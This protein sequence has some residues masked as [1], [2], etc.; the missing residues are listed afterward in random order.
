ML[1]WEAS[2]D[3]SRPIDEVFAYVTDPAKAPEWASWIL[4]NTLEG[5]GPVGVGSRIRGV[6]KFLGRSQDFR[7][8]VTQ[9]DPP[10]KFAMRTVSGGLHGYAEAQL[11][12][13]EGGTRFRNRYES[14]TGGLFKLADPI[15]APLAKRAL[16]ADL[17]T[18]KALL[19]AKV[20]TGA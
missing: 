11:E 18:L 8:E 13:I 6:W 15:V 2:V 16:E 17:H 5:G 7:G 3:I 10:S 12:S 9:Y 4:E 20:P 14:E 19:E 1:K